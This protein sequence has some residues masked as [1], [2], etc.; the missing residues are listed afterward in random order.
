[1]TKSHLLSGRNGSE[2]E[3]AIRIYHECMAWSHGDGSRIAGHTHAAERHSIEVIKNCAGIRSSVRSSAGVVRI[4][5]A[6][7]GF[8]FGFGNSVEMVRHVIACCRRD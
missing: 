5:N 7:V 6:A 4:S 3:L 8:H 1:M 2:D